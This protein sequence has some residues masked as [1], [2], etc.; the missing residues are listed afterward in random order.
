MLDSFPSEFERLPSP[1]G[2]RTTEAFRFSL[3]VVPA[4]LRVRAG[5][6]EASALT[7]ARGLDLGAAAALAALTLYGWRRVRGRLR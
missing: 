5:G 1:D 7:A 3:P 4:L 6:P 2:A